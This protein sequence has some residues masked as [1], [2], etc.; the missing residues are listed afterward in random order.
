MTTFDDEQLRL[1]LT[2]HLLE[3]IITADGDL[4]AGEV[5]FLRAQVDRASLQSAGFVDETG[6]PTPAFSK[7]RQASLLALPPRLSLKEKLDLLSMCLEAVLA[8]NQA[9]A[10]ELVHLRVAAKVVD[11]GAH[12]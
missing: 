5:D 6:A 7:A 10:Y 2:H 8:D 12:R 11:L 3:T 1:A 9:D 4:H